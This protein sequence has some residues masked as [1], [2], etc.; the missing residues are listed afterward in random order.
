MERAFQSCPL[1]VNG[2]AIDLQG[3]R[4]CGRRRYGDQHVDLP[5]SATTPIHVGRVGLRAA[6]AKRSPPITRKLLGLTETRRSG[7]TIAL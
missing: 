4:T 3:C 1:A 7:A 2:C 5:F 6:T